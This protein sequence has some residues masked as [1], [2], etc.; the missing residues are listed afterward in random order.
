MIDIETTRKKR[1]PENLAPGA[2]ALGRRALH[3]LVWMLAQNLVARGCSLVSQLALAGLLRPADFGVIGLTYT[4]TGI[5][6]T[7]TNIG[8]EDVLLQRQRA[9]RL[10]TG[11]AFWISFG[12]ALLAG[13]LVV[14]I[15]P[16]AAAAYKAPDLVGLLAILALSMPIGAL[17]SVPGMIMRARMQFGV[18]ALYGSLEITA[19]A[20]LTIGFAWAGF[21]AYSFVM[22]APILA[23]VRAVT[24]WRL[25]NSKTSFRPQRKRWRYVVGNTTAALLTRTITAVIGQGDYIILGLVASQDIVGG[26]Y[27]GFRLAAQPLWMLAGNFSGVIF[28]ALAQLKLDPKRQGDAALKASTLLSFCVMPLAML[29]AAVAAPLVTSLFGQKWASSIPIIQLLSLGLALDAVSWVAGSLLNARGEF[30]AGLRYLL[31]QAPVFFVL[32]WIGALLDQAVGVAWAVCAFYAITQPVYVY[33]V[34]RRLGISGRQV[35]LIYL[36]PTTYA[37]AAVGLGL[38]ISMLP[39]F[40]HYPLTRIAII[41]SVG[42]ALYAALV[43]WLAVDVWSELRNRALGALKRRVAA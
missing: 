25:A 16:L 5:V 34:Y 39:W 35:A 43:R 3:G 20:L 18:V 29:Q 6:A 7:L 27:F 2:V 26:Y 31:I 37:A 42:A 9:L 10:W 41:V 36:R 28:P 11:A 13:I 24:W 38:A 8:I 12:L 32:V 33:A 30:V 17:S 15:S 23:A 22:P 14:V 21:G 1:T 19:Q 4:V 40:V